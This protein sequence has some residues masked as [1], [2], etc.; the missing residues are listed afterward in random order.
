MIGGKSTNAAVRANRELAREV[1]DEIR[2]RQ[3]EPLS[4]SVEALREMQ[5]QLKELEQRKKAEYLAVGKEL[6]KDA[7]ARISALFSEINADQKHSDDALKIAGSQ[8]EQWVATRAGAYF[9]D[10]AEAQT[11]AREVQTEALSAQEK[12]EGLLSM[13]GSQFGPALELQT[14]ARAL[15]EKAT[16]M[17]IDAEEARDAARWSRKRT[18]YEGEIEHFVYNLKKARRDLVE[19]PKRRIEL[20]AKIKE[21]ESA[22]IAANQAANENDSSTLANAKK[23]RKALDS[24]RARLVSA[25]KD[26]QSAQSRINEFQGK[27]DAKLTE[28]DP[29]KPGPTEQ[30]KVAISKQVSA[31]HAQAEAMEAQ[32]K[33]CEAFQAASKLPDHSVPALSEQKLDVPDEMKDL[34]NL[35]IADLYQAAVGIES[36]LTESY[37]QL[38]AAELAMIRQIPMQRAV[39]L[40]EVTKAVRPDLNDSLRSTVNSGEEAAVARDSIQS[41]RSEINS[42]VQLGS[43]LLNQARTLDRGDGSTIAMDDY[44]EMFARNEKL[45][46]LAREMEGVGEVDLSNVMNGGNDRGGSDANGQFGGP[47]GGAEGGPPGTSGGSGGSGSPGGAPGEKG[48]TPAWFAGSIGGGGSS[49]HDPAPFGW[50]ARRI[51]ATGNSA[52]WF[53]VDSWYVIGPFDNARRANLDKKFPPE[54]TVDLNAAYPGKYDVPIRWEYQQ[55]GSANVVPRLAGFNAA[56]QDSSLDA[57]TNHRINLQYIIYYAYSELNF[58]TDCDLWVS[59][60]SDD[61]SKVWINDQLIWASGKKLKPWKLDEGYRKVHFSKG[62]NKILFRVE[63]GNDR[64]EFSFVVMLKK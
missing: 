39:E 3:L 11:N 5:R 13:V 61:F 7:P 18:S 36:S 54:T 47:A 31:R 2:E 28:P 27:L 49:N 55:S 4:K 21:A 42:M 17:V 40:T 41:A 37:R 25:I 20:E 43:S 62:R 56:R 8:I 15:Q 26:Q 48:G 60:G 10:L 35:D 33:A 19:G 46:A 30:D 34:T 32:A 9:D 24:A 51:A 64:T 45:E 38:R 50:P 44:R 52:P 22:S 14:K 29:E 16:K 57:I 12:A 59:I 1:I 58:E 6:G 53:Y 23:A 63:N